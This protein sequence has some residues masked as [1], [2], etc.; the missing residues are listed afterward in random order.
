MVAKRDGSR[1]PYAR[2]KLLQGVMLACRKRP[3]SREAMERI[4]DAV[5]AKLGEEYR[6]EV[7]S[8]ELGDMVLRQ[9]RMVD[10]VACVRFASVYHKFDT[11]EQFVE[12]LAKL[13]KGG[14]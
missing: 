13:A 8:S 12:E 6:V 11:A 5:E 7:A 2:D 10:P 14:F 1:E 3:V 9:L 4:V